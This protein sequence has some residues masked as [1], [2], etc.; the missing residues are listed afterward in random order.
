MYIIL[1][2]VAFSV[3]LRS[4]GIPEQKNIW[5]LQIDIWVQSR[6]PEWTQIDCDGLNFWV[7]EISARQG[8]I[9]TPRL[10][11]EMENRKADICRYAKLNLEISLVTEK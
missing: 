10:Y 1:I 4:I 2:W 7:Q 5:I 11:P 3:F 6:I 8:K 9:L